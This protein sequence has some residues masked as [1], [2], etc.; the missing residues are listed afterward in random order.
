[1]PKTTVPSTEIHPRL[2][3]R[4]GF[5]LVEMLTVMA[6]VGTLAGLAL[7]KYGTTVEQA[8]VA[9]AIGDLQ[10]IQTDLLSA[11]SLPDDLGGI[12]RA[13]MIDPWGTPYQYLKFPPNRRVP[14]GARRDRFLVPVNS[15]FDLYSTGKDGQSAA[16]LTARSSQDD[17]I[18]GNDGGFFGLASKF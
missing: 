13:G 5:T 11:D 10:A 16:P 3:P 15:T 4:S 9:E 14:Q 18:R 2:V 17:V 12:G 6:I 8:R 1:M 7:P